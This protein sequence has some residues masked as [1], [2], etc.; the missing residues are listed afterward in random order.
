VL[1]EWTD[2]ATATNVSQIEKDGVTRLF[3][4][5]GDY[6][7]VDHD[8]QASWEGTAA[9][10]LVAGAICGDHVVRIIHSTILIYYDISM[11]GGGVLTIIFLA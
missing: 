5:L 11:V 9:I 1:F 2:V 7:V 8:S 6:H 4:N 3:G 10:Y